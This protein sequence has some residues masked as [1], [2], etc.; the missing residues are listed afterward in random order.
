MNWCSGVRDCYG[1]CSQCVTLTDPLDDDEYPPPGPASS[2]P[3]LHLPP[4][5]ALI[6]LE[7]RIDRSFISSR[8]V[9]TLSQIRSA[10]ALRSIIFKY[11][12]GTPLGTIPRSKPWID[13]DKS[14]ARLAVQVKTKKRLTVILGCPQWE[15]CLPEFRK[16]GGE[17]KVIANKIR[18]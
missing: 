15:E 5:P 17:T 1:I 3:V 16:A 11:W 10:P 13:V 14:L 4:L 6:T 8:L 12:G 9:D 7:V 2:S 18:Q